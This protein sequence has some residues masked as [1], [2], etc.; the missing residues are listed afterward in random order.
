MCCL[1]SSNKHRVR[2]RSRALGRLRYKTVLVLVSLVSFASGPQVGQ[3]MG[4]KCPK[5]LL[6]N[7][8]LF[9]PPRME[10]GGIYFFLSVCL[11]VA[12]KTLTLEITFKP[13]RDRDFIFVM[14]T[15]V[16]KTLSNGTKCN[17]LVT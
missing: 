14:L 2:G 15:K 12:K 5:Q 3:K 11:S 1:V 17:V 6:T 7:K 9:K 8:Y 13:I 16:Y 10:F 4:F